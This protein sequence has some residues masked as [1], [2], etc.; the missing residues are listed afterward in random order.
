M[1]MLGLPVVDRTPAPQLEA[2]WLLIVSLFINSQLREFVLVD[3]YK[4]LAKNV[5]RPPHG[6][7]DQPMNH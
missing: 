2:V 6:R 7:K 1:G 5:K 3:E 4:C